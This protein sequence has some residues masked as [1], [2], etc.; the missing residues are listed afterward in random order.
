[1]KSDKFAV[2][3]LNG[4]GVHAEIKE[5][6]FHIQLQKPALPLLFAREVFIARKIPRQLLDFLGR[7][8]IVEIRRLD[9][10][11]IPFPS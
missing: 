4:V 6:V 1:M 2:A 10:I 9:D 7:G 3:I 8:G 11:G 5:R